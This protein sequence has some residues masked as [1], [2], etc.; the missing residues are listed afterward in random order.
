MIFG[1]VERQTETVLVSF[2]LFLSSLN[3][4]CFTMVCKVNDCVCQWSQ[5][6][7]RRLTNVCL[8]LN[9]RDIYY[10]KTIVYLS[11]DRFYNV[12]WFEPVSDKHEHF[13]IHI[14]TRHKKK[15]CFTVTVD[16]RHSRLLKH[17]WEI[18]FHL[19][20]KWVVWGQRYWLRYR[21]L[22]KLI[23]FRWEAS[24]LIKMIMIIKIW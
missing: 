3:E 6:G 1:T 20:C 12:V 2:I 14:F 8:S 23:L 7:L 22:T 24:S 13:L 19:R 11:K 5:L 18:Q 16:T 9:K 17:G 21:I 4:A 10:D 15:V